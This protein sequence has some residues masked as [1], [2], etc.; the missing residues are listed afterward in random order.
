MLDTIIWATDGL[1]NADADAAREASADLT[2][3]GPGRASHRVT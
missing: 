3:S 2:V 1:D